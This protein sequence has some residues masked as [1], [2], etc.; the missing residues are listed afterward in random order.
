M[1]IGVKV[2][3]PLPTLKGIKKVSNTTND[4]NS[5]RQDQDLSLQGQE[6]QHWFL[7]KMPAVDYAF[8][9]VFK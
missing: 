1:E 7:V 4:T 6:R 9:H 2:L 3:P 8:S 5:R